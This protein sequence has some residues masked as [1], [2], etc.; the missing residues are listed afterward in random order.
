MYR[1]LYGWFRLPGRH[2]HGARAVAFA[3]R[4]ACISHH[5]H[6]QPCSSGSIAQ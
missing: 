3:S 5:S 2:H 6:E 4:P 1:G